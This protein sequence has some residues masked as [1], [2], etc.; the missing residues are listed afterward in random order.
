MNL[1]TEIRYRAIELLWALFATIILLQLTQWILGMFDW[2]IAYPWNR[3]AFVIM[4][5]L[6]WSPWRPIHGAK[7]AGNND[8]FP[9]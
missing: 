4:T 2:H 8:L 9:G 7:N 6:L 5:I 3:I 1:L